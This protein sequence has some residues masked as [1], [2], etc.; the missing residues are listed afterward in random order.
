MEG[1]EGDI[2]YLT[3]T[4]VSMVNLSFLITLAILFINNYVEKQMLVDVRR[5]ITRF[6][7]FKNCVERFIRGKK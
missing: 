4:I 5:H 6:T 3:T 7:I 1:R 2:L